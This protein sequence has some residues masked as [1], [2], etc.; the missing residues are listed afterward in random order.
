M[1]K[2]LLA[3]ALF[4]STNVFCQVDKAINDLLDTKIS[5]VNTAFDSKINTI[6]SNGDT[7]TVFKSSK[8]GNINFDTL[9]IANNTA[10]RYSFSLT[11]FAT[12][13]SPWVII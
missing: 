7:I 10:R 1:K 5:A 12:A 2:I 13:S 8:I 11:G 3:L 4:L 6:L 9:Q